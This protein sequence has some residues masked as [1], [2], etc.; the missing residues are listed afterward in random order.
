M[1][2][3]GLVGGVGD[4]SLRDEEELAWSVK[5]GDQEMSLVSMMLFV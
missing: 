2:S 3:G 4:L 1:E 5:S